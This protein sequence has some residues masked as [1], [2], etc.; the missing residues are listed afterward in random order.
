MSVAFLGQEVHIMHLKE[1]FYFIAEKL[2]SFIRH[3]WCKFIMSIISTN[4]K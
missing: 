1:S 2:M 4:P 3:F